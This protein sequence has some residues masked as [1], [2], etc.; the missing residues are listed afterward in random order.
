MTAYELDRRDSQKRDH[1]QTVERLRWDC[2]QQASMQDW[3]F[4]N[5]PVHTERLEQ[6]RRYVQNWKTIVTQ[7]LGLLFWGDVGT[8]KTYLAACIANALIEQEI[9]V[10][11]VSLSSVI[12]YDFDEKSN[13]IRKLCSCPLLI[14]DDFGMER[15]TK[16]GIETAFQVIDGRY[17]SGKPLIVTT[18]LT[19]SELQ[20]PKDTDRARIYD[21]LLTM[22]TPV[23]FSGES[24]R[25]G[26]KREK[27]EILKAI[28]EQKADEYNSRSIKEV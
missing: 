3:T 12:D 6:C 15:D 16:Y 22:T 2:F 21:R 19:L 5:A 23:R 14:L 20:H 18:N 4:E 24:L 8:G 1:L 27:Q 25:H 9:P 11:M 26:S 10:R 7:N 17:V 28:F 13:Y